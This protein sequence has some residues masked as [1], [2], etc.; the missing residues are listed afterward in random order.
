MPFG[1]S[2]A[3]ATFQRLMDLVNLGLLDFMLS[4]DYTPSGE[5]LFLCI[6]TIKIVYTVQSRNT[7]VTPRH[8]TYLN[9]V[10]FCLFDFGFDHSV[11][12][13]PVGQKLNIRSKIIG[14]G[15]LGNIK[16]IIL[17]VDQCHMVQNII[18]YKVH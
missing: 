18:V 3:P 5:K 6:L 12:Q 4:K 14:K 1:S 15:F 17:N 2:N 8:V 11:N 7:Y 9:K 10:K 16:K 13:I